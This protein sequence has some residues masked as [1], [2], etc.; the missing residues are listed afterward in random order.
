MTS[1]R[2]GRLYL[3]PAL[4][5]LLAFLILLVAGAPAASART[6]ELG[7]ALNNEGFAGGGQAYRDALLR[8]D[9]VTPE[10]AMKML[11]LQPQ[12]GGYSFARADAMVS[13][14]RANG[15]PIHGHN[16]IWC[17]DTYTPAWVVQGSWTR[18]TLLAAMRDHITTVMRHWQG[19]IASWTSSTRPTRPT[20]PGATASG[21]A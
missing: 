21:S 1:A 13:W 7:T 11:E 16:L 2:G 9:A 10:S 20:A 4:R 15:R 8:Y 14:A 17:S 6:I 12:R 5:L 3:A 18:S 19:Q